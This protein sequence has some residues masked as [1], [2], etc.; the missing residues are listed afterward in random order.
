MDLHLTWLSIGAR[1]LMA[2]GGAALFVFAVKRNYFRNFEDA[3]FQVFWSDLEE[4]VERASRA[5]ATG[6]ATTR[7]EP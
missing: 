4:T 2:L 1:L 7:M 5:P 3:K 6:R